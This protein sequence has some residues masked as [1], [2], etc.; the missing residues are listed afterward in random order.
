M[1]DTNSEQNANDDNSL[2][3][4]APD[5]IKIISGGKRYSEFTP[6]ETFGHLYTVRYLYKCYRVLIK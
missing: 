1:F 2:Y 3:L 5:I 4:L 6:F